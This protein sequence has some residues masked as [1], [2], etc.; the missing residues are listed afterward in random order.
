MDKDSAD[1]VSQSVGTEVVG[2]W[3]DVRRALPHQGQSMKPSGMIFAHCWQFMGFGKFGG[4]IL[5]EQ[6]EMQNDE[7][8]SFVQFKVGHL[9][10]AATRL[11]C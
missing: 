10:V 1:A 11:A 3:G 7:I 5:T 9:K 6:R 2:I 4:T 8:D